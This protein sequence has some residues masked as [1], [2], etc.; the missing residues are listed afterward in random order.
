MLLPMAWMIERDG[1]AL[2][3]GVGDRQRDPLGAR[4]EPDDDELARASDLGDPRGFEDESRDI[5]GQLVG[6]D[7]RVHAPPLASIG[8]SGRELDASAAAAVADPRPSGGPYTAGRMAPVSRA[9][10]GGRASLPF[11]Q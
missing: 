5:R 8:S 2:G 6:R 9:V 7:D 3:V 1:P 4:P 11:G 10:A